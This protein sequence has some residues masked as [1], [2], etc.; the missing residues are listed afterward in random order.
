LLQSVYVT[1]RT[2]AGL[3]LGLLLMYVF[4]VPA[5]AAEL[6]GPSIPLTK[7][8]KTP[9]FIAQLNG[10]A[11]DS[12]HGPAVFEARG[13]Y[14][15]GYAAGDDD[16]F[17]EL[18]RLVETTELNAMVIDVKDASG[19]TTYL[20]EVPAVREY[21][22]YSDKIRDLPGRVAELLK[23]GIYPIARLVVFKDPVLARER[24]DLAVQRPDGTVWVDYNGLAWT[25]PYAREVWEYNLAIA[26]EVAA[27]GFK[28]IQFDYVRFPSDGPLSL[29]V[30]PG[31]TGLTRSMV[32]ASFLTEARRQLAEDGVVISADI[33]GL[34]V[35]AD[36]DLGIGQY[37][38]AIQTSVDVVCPMV[39][40][41]HYAPH[42]F[43]LADPD[44][45]PYEVVFR[46]MQDAVRRSRPGGAIIRP[47]LQD[48]SLGHTYG[49]A[50]V[51]RQIEAAR[52]AGVD[53]WLLWNPGSRYTKAA[54]REVSVDWE[55][56]PLLR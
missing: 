56:A 15:S 42:S 8:L 18:V 48:F 26:R 40:P 3:M 54:L 53:Q 30:Y 22:A 16:R 6:R 43:G 11:D 7:V 51:R 32:I 27:M 29:A 45:S 46:A 55:R 25:N 2:L 44:A 5:D 10:T 38:E 19:K 47:W 52:E 14:L 33:F 49:P 4:G 1:K 17:Y 35:S 24:P 21:G 28:E 9:L 34:V 36:D 37:Y 50:E 20:S 13:I 39:Y 23:R 12:T 41:S 31:R